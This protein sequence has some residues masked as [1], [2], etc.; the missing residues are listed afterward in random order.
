MHGT[1]AAGKGGL[2]VWIQIL[3]LLLTTHGTLSKPL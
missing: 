1:E 3:T 2:E